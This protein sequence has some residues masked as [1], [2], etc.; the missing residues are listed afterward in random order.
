M[1]FFNSYRG[2]ILQY[3]GLSK[4]AH[5]E[6]LASQGLLFFSRALRSWDR[7]EM[8]KLVLPSTKDS[9]WNRVSY[10]LVHNMWAT[11]ARTYMMHNEHWYTPNL[12]MVRPTNGSCYQAI[13]QGYVLEMD[14]TRMLLLKWG[15]AIWDVHRLERAAARHNKL[16]LDT[17]RMRRDV[18]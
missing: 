7:K 5:A 11:H 15:Y 13:Q 4:E 2:S 3:V 12:S 14:H 1:K 16:Y 6:H 10:V 9:H 17:S 8:D 18:P